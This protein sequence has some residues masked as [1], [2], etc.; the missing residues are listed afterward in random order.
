MDYHEDI[1]NQT[2]KNQTTGNVEIRCRLE[3]T[4]KTGNSRL[5]RIVLHCLM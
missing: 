4:D 3:K 5:K 2:L 1:A